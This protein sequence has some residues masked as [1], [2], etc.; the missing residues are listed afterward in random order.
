MS[1]KPWTAQQRELGE[2]MPLMKVGDFWEC[3]SIS[4]PECKQVADNVQWL[5]MDRS[6][7]VM[8]KDD[9]VIR[10]VRVA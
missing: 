5:I 6:F 2:I 9:G 1:N 10:V 4:K 8:T 3:G 7:A